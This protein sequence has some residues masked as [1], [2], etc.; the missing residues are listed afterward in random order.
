MD[1]TCDCQSGYEMNIT[2]DG[3]KMCG[4]VNDCGARACGLHGKCKDLVNDYTCECDVGYKMVTHDKEKF[5]DVVECGM[6][7]RVDNAT[8]P[9]KKFAFKQ[10]VVYTCQPGFE[11]AGT[12]D[13]TFSI[14]CKS[15][16]S[17]SPTKTCSPKSCG[18]PPSGENA[19]VA[20][21]AIVCGIPDTVS[22]AMVPSASL[23]YK[24]QATYTC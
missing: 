18:T 1:Y 15:D 19:D 24:Q 6:P 4:N 8:W 9:L 7:P 16:K 5:C 10:T 21:T 12:T 22:E 17:F 20:T 13:S 23:T 2:A 14:E 3:E 11:V